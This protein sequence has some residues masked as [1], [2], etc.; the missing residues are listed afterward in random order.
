MVQRS[1]VPGGRARRT[2]IALA[3]VRIAANVVLALASMI[4]ELGDSPVTGTRN[5]SLGTAL[6]SSG[7]IVS[8]PLVSMLV[9]SLLLLGISMRRAWVPRVASVLFVI[10]IGIVAFDT[11]GGLHAQAPLYGPTR[12][13]FVVIVGWLF[14]A[15]SAATVSA[16]LFHLS[17]WKEH[18]AT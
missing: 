17:R 14:V 3:L 12:W 15:L 6:W 10:V 5:V 13:A 16:G 1:H 18:A 7:T 2:F 8:P 4:F 11:A 9:A